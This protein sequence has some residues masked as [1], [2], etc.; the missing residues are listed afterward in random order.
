MSAHPLIRTLTDDDCEAVAEVRVRGWQYAYAGLVPQPYLDGMDVGT[1]AE[2]LRGLI[3]AGS[4]TVT[5]LV[6]ERDGAVVGWGCTGAARDDDTAPGEA[7]LY[8]LYVR[9][10]RLSTGVG[11]ALLAELTARA[12]AAGHPA[13]RL[14]VLRENVR[15]RRFYEKAGFRPDGAEEPFDVGGASVPE[16][17]YVRDL[18][19]D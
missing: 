7:E 14:W 9:P 5:H 3:A 16:V 12:R 19:T 4:G 11:R 17:R 2:R 18:G 8:A 15:A 1:E 6:A 13:M 10:A